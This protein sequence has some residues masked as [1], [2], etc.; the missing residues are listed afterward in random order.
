MIGI[1]GTR[2]KAA[3]PKVADNSPHAIHT[4]CVLAV[5]GLQRPLKTVLPGRYR[6]RVDVV[7][8][9][10]VRKDGQA[11]AARIHPEKIEIGLGV[12]GREKHWFAMIAALGGVVRDAWK[13]DSG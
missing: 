3:L 8:H 9:K 11:G 13:N 12:T 1:E 4:L 2:A 5:H 10:A 6:D 7:R